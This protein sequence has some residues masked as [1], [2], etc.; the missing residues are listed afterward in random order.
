MKAWNFIGR[1]DRLPNPGD[2]FTLCFAGF[3]IIVLR[4]K[5]GS[6]AHSQ[7]PA[8]IEARNCSAAAM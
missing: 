8:G 2:Y 5:E 1:A 3:P 4:D 7:K 6:C